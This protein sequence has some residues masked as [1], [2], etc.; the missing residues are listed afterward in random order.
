MTP[1]ALLEENRCF[2]FPQIKDSKR[3]W[4]IATWCPSCLQ[5]AFEPVGSAAK[6]FAWRG[7]AQFQAHLPHLSEQLEDQAHIFRGVETTPKASLSCSRRVCRWWSALCHRKR[8]NGN[9]AVLWPGAVT[10]GR[11][12]T[13]HET[14]QQLCLS[15]L[16]PHFFC[17]VVFFSVVSQSWTPKVLFFSCSRYSSLDNVLFSVG[18]ISTTT[19]PHCNVDGTLA[20]AAALNA[21]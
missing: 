19:L 16:P 8:S 12:L 3:E 10:A 1:E 7:G 18:A 14:F 4:R 11:R 21:C 6:C 17:F 15:R 5:P 2:C 20:A 13:L 9:D